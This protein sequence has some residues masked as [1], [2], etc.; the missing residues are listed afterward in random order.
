MDN[1]IRPASAR[2]RW[3]YLL[4]AYLCVGLG[5]LGVLLPGLPTTPF[6]LVAVWAANRG[7]GR[8]H[9]WLTDHPRFGPLLRDWNEQGAVPRRAKGV[10][11]A[12]MALSWGVMLA[13]TDGPLVP[14][15]TGALFLLVGGYLVTRPA[16][17][18]A[19]PGEHIAVGAS[20]TP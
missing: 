14:M 11:I 3:A 10:G 15:T 20:G 12:L 16:P 4:L 1:A 13:L 8:L 9:A 18:R 19:P 7:S 5:L 17:R 6:L 2:L